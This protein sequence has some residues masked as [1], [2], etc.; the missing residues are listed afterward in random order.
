MFIFGRCCHSLA[1]AT[2]VKYEHNIQLVTTILIIQK[3]EENDGTADT[4]LVPPTTDLKV[5]APDCDCIVEGQ[6]RQDL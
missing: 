4:D 3:N 6:V 5:M 2:L 1:V